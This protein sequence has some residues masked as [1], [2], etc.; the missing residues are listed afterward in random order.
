MLCN[1]CVCRFSFHSSRSHT[2]LHVFNHFSLVWTRSWPLLG[3]NGDLQPFWRR[4]DTVALKHYNYM[5]K[6]SFTRPESDSELQR[7]GFPFVPSAVSLHRLTDASL[8]HIQS[9]ISTLCHFFYLKF[10]LSF[11]TWC[12]PY[13]WRRPGWLPSASPQICFT[14][15]FPINPN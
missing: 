15:Y 7:G 5:H 13:S 8:I 6:F 11:R 14:D 3:Q 2:Q 1:R 4:L 12:S 10:L 9:R